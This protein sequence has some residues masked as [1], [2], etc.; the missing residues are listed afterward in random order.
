MKKYIFF[1]I[2]FA[3]AIAAC[4]TKDGSKTSESHIN[5]P[6]TAAYTT[7]FNNNVSD[8]DL[9]MVLNSYKYWETG[10]LKGLRSTMGDSMYVNAADGFKFA[11]LTDSLMKN[12]Q[13]MR[14]SL[15]SVKITMDVWLKNHAIKDSSNYINVWYKEI[16]T[17]KDGKVDSAN[18]EDDNGLKNGK[19]IMFS[20]HRQVLK[21]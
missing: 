11:G 21:P 10:D 5:L 15:S 20:S 9:L 1:S 8:S 16:D 6:Y 2:A 4:K 12:W 18:Y 13:I 3:V 19:I 14:D 7:D 17:Y